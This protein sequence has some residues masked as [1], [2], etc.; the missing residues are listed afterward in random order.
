MG[1][2]PTGSPA[3]GLPRPDRRRPPGHRPEVLLDGWTPPP[4]SGSGSP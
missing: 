2:D 3:A 4:R 1:V